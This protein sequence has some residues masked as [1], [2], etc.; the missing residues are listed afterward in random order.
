MKTRFALVMAICLMAFVG[1]VE[2]TI[3]L[4][5]LDGTKV[6]D[7]NSCLVEQTDSYVRM[8]NVSHGSKT[9]AIY[10][11]V[12]DWTPYKAMRWTIENKSTY[13]LS[14]WVRVIEKDAK[15]GKH[16][17]A[18]VLLRKYYIEPQSVRKITLEMPAPAPYPEV[19]DEFRL[20]KND[21]YAYVSGL[22][23]WKVD[24][25]NVE[26]VTFQ[27]NRGYKDAEWIIS[28]IELIEGE[29]F[30]PDAMNM[31]KDEF[32]PFID[33]YGQFKHTE[34]PGKVKS[35]ADLE[36]ARIAE[37]KDLAANPGP[38]NFTK[39]GGWAD[40]PKF[41]ATGHF[42]VQK[43]DGKWW[44]IDPEGYL[45]WSHGIVRVSHSNAV[46]PLEGENLKNR[47]FYFE[48]LPDKDSDFYQFYYTHDQLLKPYYTARGIDSTYDFSSANLY[49]KYGEDYLAD[50]NDICHRRLRSWG[51]NTIANSS[52]KEICLM[53]RTPYMDRF[54]V[55]SVSFPGTGGWWPVM[56]PY[57]PSFIVSLEKQLKDRKRE[58][59]DPWCLGFFVDNEIA[60]GHPTNIAEIVMKCP[61]DQAAKKH[62][63]SVLKGK[64]VTINALNEAWGTKFDSW[65]AL[66]QN[67]KAV[68]TNDRNRADYLEFNRGVI[69]KYYSNIR[70]A[71]DRLAPGVLYMGCRFA[72]YTPDL[73]SIG[74]EYCDVISYNI[75]DFTLDKVQLPEGVDKPIMI[76]EFHFGAQDRGMFHC[77]QVEVESQKNRG[78]AYVRY[79]ESGLRHPNIIGVHWHQYS[80]QATSAR[81]CGENF[82]VG[83]TDVCDTPY[84]ETIDA[85]RNIGYRMYEFRNAAK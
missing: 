23:S 20:M 8:K 55:V 31:S 13:P 27:S 2:K 64:Y 58:L 75:Y 29:K 66:A 76:G 51:L 84:P 83:F 63:L 22:H 67:R 26:K 4:L 69:H 70:G 41:E 81:F 65:N 72:G 54:E 1:C 52:D 16:V 78:D 74:A 53:D 17:S 18:G 85:A 40:G 43:I 38:K 71:F 25:T 61:A 39:Y 37:E 35:D 28:D 5:A 50:F 36:K 59:E 14:L 7:G 45:F 77:S 48:D 3:N 68:K 80:D 10:P 46:T 33:K 11:A 32:Y 57:D 30:L 79:V 73:V 15:V 9:F 44:M 21:P 34:W 24:Y 12:N 49:R 47:S 19:A 42:R 60:W 6:K 62:F 82:Q 56:D